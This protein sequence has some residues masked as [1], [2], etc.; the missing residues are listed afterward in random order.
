MR[1]KVILA[2]MVI[3]ASR[4]QATP[5]QWSTDDGG[6]GHFY[7]VVL[8]SGVIDWE[9]A[10]VAAIEAG[11]YL[12][13]ITS[14]EEN[15]FVHNLAVSNPDFW[16]SSGLMG[17][18]LGGF[19]PDGSPEPAG[20]WQ[21]VTGEPFIYTNWTINE[22]DNGNEAGE[23][24]LHFHDGRTPLAYAPTWNDVHSVTGLNSYVVEVV[25]EPTT[26]LLFGLGGI[27]LRKRRRT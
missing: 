11:G 18:W 24:R 9:N 3:F 7:E 17:P 27:L 13:T 25:P 21:W 22:P 1:S 23:N 12:A 20:G 10:N 5:V 19:Q 16:H 14:V 2:V 4:C 15:A 8:V 6:N 26:F